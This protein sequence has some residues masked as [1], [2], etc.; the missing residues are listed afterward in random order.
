MLNHPSQACCIPRYEHRA[1]RNVL[2]GVGG[3]GPNLGGPGPNL[4][5]PNLGGP[6][7]GVNNPG[8]HLASH[9]GGAV[10]TPCPQPCAPACPQ[11]C[12]PCQPPCP[13][14]PLVP[15]D[16][17]STRRAVATWKVNYLVSNRSNQAAHLDQE[18]VNPWGIAVYNNQLWVINNYTDRITNYD[19]FGNRLL[20][21]IST[22]DAQHDSTFP[23][24]I[25][26]NCGAG[27]NVSNGGFTKAGLLV[28]ASESGTVSV[29]NPNV[30]QLDSFIILNKQLT[31]VITKY[32]GLAIANGILY[33]ADF[34]QSQID[35]FDS[36]Y[37]RLLGYHFIDGDTSD[38]IPLDYGPVNIVHIGCFMYVLWSKKDPNITIHSIEGPGLGY[39]S[40]FNPDGSFVRRFTSRGVLNNPWAMIPAPC[41]C[42]YPSGSFIVSNHGDG[43]CNV[44]DCNGRYVG[45]LL[46]QDG[47]PLTISGIRGLAPYY[48]DFNEIFFTAA[49]E[50]NIEGL[51]GSFVRDQIIYF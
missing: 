19:L 15:A 20:G 27:F 29:Y 7:L 28:T 31:G 41:E 38:P 35:V 18:L 36:A 46:N 24:G 25:A 42:G 50:E 14:G 22:R 33:L 21:S 9:V 44:F 12:A 11:P 5:G 48:T 17:F 43:R 6:N 49:Y 4:G 10:Q 45:P 13:P 1:D 32:K 47:L 51:M 34:N 2:G 40:V 23:T 30:N 8:Q 16:P 39:I 37:N 3:P 26:I